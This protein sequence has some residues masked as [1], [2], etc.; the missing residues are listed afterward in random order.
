MR[1]EFDY[2]SPLGWLGGIADRLFLKRYMT[3]FLERRNRLI[4]KEAEAQWFAM[5]P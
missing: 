2:E 4:E 5:P 3:Q 1:D